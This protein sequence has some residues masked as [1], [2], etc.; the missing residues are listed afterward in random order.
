MLIKKE[1]CRIECSSSLMI[2]FS[3]G[4]YGLEQQSADLSEERC[5][6]Y[7]RDRHQVDEDVH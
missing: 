4:L 6:Y 1:S 5:K 3:S 7:S 2:C